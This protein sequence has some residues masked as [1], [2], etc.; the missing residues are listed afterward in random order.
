M[1]KPTRRDI[2]KLATV[3][4]IV[5]LPA[6]IV[7]PPEP[8]NQPVARLEGQPLP[9]ECKLTYFEVGRTTVT[10]IYR[11]WRSGSHQVRP[12]R[13]LGRCWRSNEAW[14]TLASTRINHQ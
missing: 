14:L 5:G 3:A 4:P 6:R 12:W 1:S 7:K 8:P 13:D 9:L 2:I 10:A 11:R